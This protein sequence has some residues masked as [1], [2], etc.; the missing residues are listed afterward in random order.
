MPKLYKVVSDRPKYFTDRYHAGV[1]AKE[2]G[3]I[4]ET[5]NV[6]TYLRDW[7]TWLN[8]NSQPVASRENPLVVVSKEQPEPVVA[9]HAVVE[10]VAN[11]DAEHYAHIVEL[12]KRVIND[13]Q[14]KLD[15]LRRQIKAQQ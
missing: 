12:Q 6:P 14:L 5:V 8:E 4:V 3:A 10:P 15:E 7:V 2:R 13:M 11:S 9:E 1:H